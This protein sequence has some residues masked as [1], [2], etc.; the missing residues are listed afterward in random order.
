MTKLTNDHVQ[1]L[2]LIFRLF[3]G[4]EQCLFCQKKLSICSL[5][6]TDCE[7]EGLGDNELVFEFASSTLLKQLSTWSSFEWATAVLT[8]FE[9]STFGLFDSN[10]DGWPIGRLNFDT[11]ADLQRY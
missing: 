7:V 10:T 2:F 4:D 1:Y 6:F 3:I 5:V 9:S 8:P 11:I